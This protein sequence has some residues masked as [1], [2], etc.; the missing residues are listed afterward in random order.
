MIS[1]STDGELFNYKQYF[2][3]LKI[4]LCS[5]IK[6]VA[7]TAIAEKPRYRVG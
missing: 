3:N 6:Q 1:P 7:H 5:Q 2:N 4:Q